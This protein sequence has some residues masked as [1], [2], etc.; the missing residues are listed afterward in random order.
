MKEILTGIGI[1]LI[2]FGLVKLV[3]AMVLRRKEKRH[4]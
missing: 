1:L 3:L 4:G 2:C